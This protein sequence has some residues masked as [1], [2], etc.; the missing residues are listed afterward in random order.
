MLIM[1]CCKYNKTLKTISN[2][3]NTPDSVI[4]HIDTMATLFLLLGVMYDLENTSRYRPS[5]SNGFRC[6]TDKIHIH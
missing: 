4:I 5:F 1:K 2:G 6:L 3:S